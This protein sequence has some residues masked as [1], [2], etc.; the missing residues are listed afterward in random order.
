MDTHRRAR[1]AGRWCHAFAV[2]EESHRELRF[3]TSP[4]TR[5]ARWN[6]TSAANRFKQVGRI[7]SF[8]SHTA[9][10]RN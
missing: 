7:R 8:R 5:K 1:I 3:S 10:R 6:K 9:R 4:R 2:A